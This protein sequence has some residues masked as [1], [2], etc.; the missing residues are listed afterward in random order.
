MFIHTEPKRQRETARGAQWTNAL[1]V[2]VT[3]QVPSSYD[4]CAIFKD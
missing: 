3:P 4:V 1:R 2:R